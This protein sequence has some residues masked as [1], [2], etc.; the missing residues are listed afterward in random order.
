MRSPCSR[1]R[2]AGA[3]RSASNATSAPHQPRNACCISIFADVRLDQ[4]EL[5]QDDD[6]RPWTHDSA[7]V[8]DHGEVA[9]FFAHRC[10]GKQACRRERRRRRPRSTSADST[11][12][13]PAGRSRSGRP[14]LRRET[15]GEQ[16]QQRER[17]DEETA[18]DPD[19]IRLRARVP[20]IEHAAGQ[21]ND[22]RR[23]NV[24]QATADQLSR[25][26]CG[27]DDR[28]AQRDGAQV[29]RHPDHR[30]LVVHRQDVQRKVA[31][32]LEQA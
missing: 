22:E 10:D 32:I 19:V 21:E 16:D 5:L 31:V 28:R 23:K 9:G 26:Q 1:M 14:E 17:A 18:G 7:R 20:Q 24:E 29:P 2:C 3:C 30:T 4:R 6:D 11:C 25:Q 13:R 8:F 27:A 15:E 12:G